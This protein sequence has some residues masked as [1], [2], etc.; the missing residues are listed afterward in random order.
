MPVENWLPWGSPSQE[1]LVVLP[2]DPSGQLAQV[3]LR[4]GYSLTGITSQLEAFLAAY[5]PAAH[6][7]G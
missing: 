5:E 3:E 6:V 2:E 7:T 1:A 4:T